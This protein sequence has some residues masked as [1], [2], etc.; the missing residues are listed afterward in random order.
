MTRHLTALTELLT[1]AIY[2]ATYQLAP[3]PRQFT[4]IFLKLQPS[5]PKASL[6]NVNRLPAVR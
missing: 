6:N 1:E 4:S 5:S 3:R 2:G